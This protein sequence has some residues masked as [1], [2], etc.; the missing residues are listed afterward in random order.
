MKIYPKNYVEKE[1]T[2][3]ELVID[4]KKETEMIAKA[5]EL[6]GDEPMELKELADKLEQYY[7]FE[8]NEHYTSEQLRQICEQ[9]GE[10]KDVPIEE[11]IEDVIEPIK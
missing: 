4:N 6:L 5:N 1:I 7:V 8:K 11:V 3:G 10:K 9:A 2:S